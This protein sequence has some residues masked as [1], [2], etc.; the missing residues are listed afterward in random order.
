VVLPLALLGFLVFPGV[1]L[2]SWLGLAVSQSLP[3]VILAGILLAVIW[4]PAAR[5]TDPLP[6]YGPTTVLL[7]TTIVALLAGIGL[8]AFTEL[9]AQSDI[10]GPGWSFRGN[11]ALVVPFAGGPTVLAAGWVMLTLWRRGDGRWAWG[12]L[13]AGILAMAVSLLGGLVRVIAGPD[14]P[15]ATTLLSLA[16]ALLS[17]AGGLLLAARFAQLSRWGVLSSLVVTLLGAW[18]F[19]PFA[20]LLAPIVL[21]LPLV[22]TPGARPSPGWRWLAAGFALILIALLAGMLG[23]G[24]TFSRL[25]PG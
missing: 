13:A 23:A 25:G 22:L 9:V 7:G 14:A 10:S 6:G 3:F 21:V 17:F 15:L 16:V 2:L 12:G 5:A 24:M 4:S 19:L 20:P 11:G 1:L 8:W 18:V